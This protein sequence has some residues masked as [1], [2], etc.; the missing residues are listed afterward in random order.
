MTYQIFSKTQFRHI[1]FYICIIFNL[2]QMI[3]L[4]IIAPHDLCVMSFYAS[5]GNQGSR[6]EVVTWKLLH[7]FNSPL[8]CIFQITAHTGK[9]STAAEVLSLLVHHH[10]CFP[11]I[12]QRAPLD[13]CGSFRKRSSRDPG[14]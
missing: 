14:H 13:Q 9:C 5:S 6:S 7:Q 4:T 10:A 2:G 12:A 3:L 11:P 1:L 8:Q